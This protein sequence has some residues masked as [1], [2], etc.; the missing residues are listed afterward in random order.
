MDL[1]YVT[2]EKIQKTGSLQLTA[3][4]LLNYREKEGH[5]RRFL[6]SYPNSREKFHRKYS[7]RV[8]HQKALTTARNKIQVYVAQQ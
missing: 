4:N 6:Q 1:I 2:G 7:L 8:L 5:H 3:G